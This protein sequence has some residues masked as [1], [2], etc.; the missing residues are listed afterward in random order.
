ME[1]L[2]NLLLFVIALSS[3]A[4]IHEFGHLLV[5]K[6]FNVYCSEF[7]IGMGPKLFGFKYKETEYN[8]RAFL[9][10]GFVAMAGDGE[11]DE[12]DT[13]KLNVPEDRT[14]R[15]LHPFKKILVMYAGIFMNFILAILIVG[16]VLLDGGVYGVSSKPVIKELSE[17]YPAY[18]SGLMVGDE[19][20]RVEFENGSSINVSSYTEMSTFLEMYDGNGY[21]TL[22]VSR[23]DQTLTISVMPKYVVEE[24]RYLIGASFETNKYVEVNIINCWGYALDYLYMITKLTVNALLELFVGIGLNNLSGPV[25]IY[26]TVSEVS[27][28]GMEYYALLIGMLSL[29][30]G[31]MN[32]LPIPVMDG[33]RVFITLI[34]WI[35]GKPLN[36]KVE[37]FLMA[38]SIGLLAML[39]ILVTYKDILNLL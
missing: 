36:K 2:K 3:I 29:N 16:L 6:A 5:A 30:V 19:I 37:S 25:G 32:A 34:E 13:D 17:N 23:D 28:M 20:Q 14:L 7:S 21:W 1:M 9:L 35:I 39:F 18:D 11:N 31:I 15:A 10:G 8:V 38:A 26:N 24:D 12:N 27:S 22:T 33:G 4:I